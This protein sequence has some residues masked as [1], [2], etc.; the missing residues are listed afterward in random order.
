MS[1]SSVI[2]DDRCILEEVDGDKFSSEIFFRLDSEALQGF[3]LDLC[4]P[5]N[6]SL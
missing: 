6:I 1:G 3:I 2:K 4:R 5:V